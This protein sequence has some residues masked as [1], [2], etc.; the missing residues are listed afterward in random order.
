[1]NKIYIYIGIA[2]I[3][4]GILWFI[5]KSDDKKIATE[6]VNK[7]IN[8][9]ITPNQFNQMTTDER[10]QITPERQKQIQQLT[11]EQIKQINQQTI[12]SFDNMTPNQ[13]LNIIHN[14]TDDNITDD[15]KT[16][17]TCGKF[18]MLLNQLIEAIEADKSPK[19]DKVYED[20]EFLK[21]SL[22]EFDCV[23]YKDYYNIFINV[24]KIIYMVIMGKKKC[25]DGKTELDT[26]L[27]NI[28][29][30]HKML[31]SIL[32]TVNDKNLEDKKLTLEQLKEEINKMRNY[33]TSRNCE[34]VNKKLQ[35]AK[36]L[37]NMKLKNIHY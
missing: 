28:E 30:D 3:I 37:Y 32:K 27:K 26:I 12:D 9:P 8:Q 7:M 14:M 23:I 20:L 10:Q 35:K 21:T 34:L 36:S 5:F 18:K 33:V 22:N 15:N 24:I 13:I 25:D 29:G 6:F 11:P 1:M 31:T 2:V 17:I 16:K 4:L 19:F